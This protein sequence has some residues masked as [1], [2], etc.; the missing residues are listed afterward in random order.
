MNTLNVCSC[1]RTGAT[2][3]VAPWTGML[4]D[5]RRNP[6]DERG[7]VGWGERSEPQHS[8]PDSAGLHPGY[9]L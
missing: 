9:F 4:G 1:R 7:G 6:P 3:F 8:F 5:F 2:G